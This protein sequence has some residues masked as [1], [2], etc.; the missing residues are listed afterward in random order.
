MSMTGKICVVTGANSGI[1]RETA[2]ALAKAHADVS[3]V[4]RTAEKA[5]AAAAEIRARSGSDR[6]R[7][8]VADFSSQAETRALAKCLLA[9]LPRIDVL[10]N[11]AGLIMG[12]RRLTPEGIETTF[13][14]NHL[15]YFLLTHLLLDRLRESAPA[16]IVN[17]ASDAHRSGT[18]DF[19]DIECARGYSGWKAYCQSKLCNVLFTNELARRL[20]GSGITANSL[21]PGV[22]GT[23]FANAG[24]SLV[25][26]LFWLA[27]PFLLSPARGAETSIYL[28]MS[29]DVDGVSGKYFAK[30]QAVTP[31]SEARDEQRAKRLWTLSESMTGISAT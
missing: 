26:G 4:C 25:R 7:A 5:E 24:P 14:V 27:K 16:R 28:A 19:D 12:E 1:G 15:G 6:V 21:H 13:A 2:V 22:V 20:D 31:S 3:I 23:N 30:K 18:V 11:N 17:V 8:F 10:V 29:P 9:E